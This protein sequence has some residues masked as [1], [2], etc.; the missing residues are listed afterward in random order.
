[1][2]RPW[3]QPSSA[4]AATSPCLAWWRPSANS[5]KRLRKIGGDK[6]LKLVRREP[7]ELIIRIVSG[8]SQ[9]FNAKRAAEL[10]FTAETSFEEIVRAHVDD[11][12]GGKVA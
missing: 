4:G 10:G 3:T 11:E 7:D 12:L 5:W 9:R 8:W 1:M 2:P 6:A